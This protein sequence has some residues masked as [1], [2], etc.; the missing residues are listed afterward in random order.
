MEE[1]IKSRKFSE[2]QSTGKLENKNKINNDI[3][4]LISKLKLHNFNEKNNFF[5][6]HK[7]KSYPLVE[8]N[9]IKDEIFLENHIS[10]KKSFVSKNAKSTNEC[11]Q[12]ISYKQ[13]KT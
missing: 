13:K 6:Y 4:F 5:N 10:K 9:N 3:D 7:L 1:K 11:N 12:K 8:L 2:K